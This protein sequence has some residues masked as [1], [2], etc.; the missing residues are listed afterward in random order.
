[1]Q[2]S[3]VRV[4]WNSLRSCHAGESAAE[5]ENFVARVL[6]DHPEWLRTATVVREADGRTLRLLHV[7]A[8][9]SI[10]AFDPETG[11][12]EFLSK[13]SP[14]VRNAQW[15]IPSSRSQ[16]TG[17]AAMAMPPPPPASPSQPSEDTAARNSGGERRR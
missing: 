8:S 6:R 10:V 12:K 7:V 14:L 5:A 13:D 11:V 4:G 16:Q 2:C 3:S 17:T 1:M 9:S 15:I